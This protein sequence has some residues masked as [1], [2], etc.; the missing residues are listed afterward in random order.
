MPRIKVCGVF[1]NYISH[2]KLPKNKIF[3][4]EEFF[5]SRLY[6]AEKQEEYFLGKENFVKGKKNVGL[7]SPQKVS[8]NIT[9]GCNLKC[10]HCFTNAGT[11]DQNEL[12]SEELF[13]LID[14]MKDA[15]SFFMA[16]GGGEPLLRNDLFEVIGYARDHFI[17]V[18][19]VTNGLLINEEIARKFNTFNLDTITVSLDGLEENHDYIRGRGNFK[20]TIESLKTLRKYCRTAKLAIRFTVNR[21]NINECEKMIRLAERLSL[22]FI[23]LTPMLLL[24]RVEKNQ[25]LLIT[26]D[27]YICFLK[28]TQ[29]IESKIKVVLPHREDANKWFICPE[30]FGCHCGKEACWITQTGDFYPC[31]FFGEKFL[32]GNIKNEKFLDLWDKA[33]NMV[34]LNGNETCKNCVEYKKCRGGCRARA[35]REYG[36]INA[37]E[38]LC[39]LRKNMIY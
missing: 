16:I 18:S 17:A 22:D 28:D 7:S 38:P 27:Q 31:I 23:R 13:K 15:G 20:K 24:G 8:L 1:V 37:V 29:N 26:Q 5:G 2:M 35:L 30:D 3:S 14:Q 11:P 6:D 12:T 39:P 19:I 25:D 9:R 10:K 21:R 34:K 33:K 4:R 36:D 32:A